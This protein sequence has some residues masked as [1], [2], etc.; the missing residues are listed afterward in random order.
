MTI[1][2]SFIPLWVDSLLLCLKN[3]FNWNVTSQG[4]N[5]VQELIDVYGLDVVQAYMG[6][7]QQ[8]AELAVRE[9]LRDI[10]R[11]TPNQ[12]L[13]ATEYLDDGSPIH[14]SVTVD[15]DTGSAICDFRSA[16]DFLWYRYTSISV[17]LNT[18]N[19]NIVG[20]TLYMTV[21]S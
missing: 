17:Q 7:I 6:H 19:I 5:L 15:T 12:P 18:Q 16:S 13:C 21:S 3:L 11:V 9:M 20:D 1:N 2:R 10:G 4:I 14:L 8:N